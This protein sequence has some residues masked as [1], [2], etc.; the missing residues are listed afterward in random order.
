MTPNKAPPSGIS[1]AAVL[2]L[3]SLHNS[4][5]RLAPLL[6]P[7]Q[8]AEL[9][10]A[11]FKDIVHTLSLC[12]DIH[13][14]VVVTSDP[15]VIRIAQHQRI[16]IIPEPIESGLINA[17]TQAGKILAR[18]NIQRMIFIPSDVPLVS[19]EEIQA[20]LNPTSH[21]T[22]V[23]DTANVTANDPS[24]NSN[25]A[26]IINIV[27]AAD[28]GGSNCISC[29]P[30]DCMEFSFGEQSFSRHLKIAQQLNLST[31]VTQSA[32]LGLDID[33]PKDLAQLSKE[34]NKQLSKQLNKRPDKQP[35]TKPS[36]QAITART[37]QQAAQQAPA[38]ENQAHT[39]TYRF[40]LSHGF[41]NQSHATFHEAEPIRLRN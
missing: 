6:N 32:G 14:I 24:D 8:R 26:G 13:K 41:L 35:S 12:Q 19:T 37:S 11:M 27:P 34:L 5:Q 18:E 21:G 23:N 31:W 2:P 36:K 40:L 3:K 7:Q 1:T 4:K 10:L 16:E 38:Q 25:T 15:Q 17:V 28:S 30:P 33:T 29:T 9:T 22:R 20:V 39:H